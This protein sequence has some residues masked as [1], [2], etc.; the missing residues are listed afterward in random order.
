[1]LTTESPAAMQGFFL[2]S[3]NDI[4]ASLPTAMFVNA[5]STVSP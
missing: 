2:E 4:A 5:E 1:M 3:P